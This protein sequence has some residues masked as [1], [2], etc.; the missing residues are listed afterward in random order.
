MKDE[1]KSFLFSVLSGSIWSV[2]VP[3]VSSR[4][5]P[6]NLSGEMLFYKEKWMRGKAFTH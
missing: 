3:L 6:A 4:I 2:Q 5:L 1:E